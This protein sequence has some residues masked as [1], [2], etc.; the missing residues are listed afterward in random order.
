MSACMYKEV[1]TGKHIREGCLLLDWTPPREDHW[2]QNNGYHAPYRPQDPETSYLN[3]LSLKVFVFWCSTWN[4]ETGANRAI[5]LPCGAWE[6]ARHWSSVLKQHIWYTRLCY[7]LKTVLD[8][9]L[10]DNVNCVTP[11]AMAAILWPWRQAEC[12]SSVNQN[13]STERPQQMFSPWGHHSTLELLY[14]EA[15][16]VRYF[17]LCLRHFD[18]PNLYLNLSSESRKEKNSPT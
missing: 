6:L 12:E 18:L 9:L 13:G 17:P 14:T 5:L 11:G 3:S 1:H 16:W 8:P 15:S 10:L 4:W 7:L 2:T